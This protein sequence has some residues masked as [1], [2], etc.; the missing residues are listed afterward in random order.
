MPHSGK[1][2]L[3]EKSKSFESIHI[4]DEDSDEDSDIDIA[5]HFLFYHYANTSSVNSTF[6]AQSFVFGKENIV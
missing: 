6:L 1:R 3:L 5:W 4:I 2:R